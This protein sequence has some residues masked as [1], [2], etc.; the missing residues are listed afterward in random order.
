MI[1]ISWH[2]LGRYRTNSVRLYYTRPAELSKCFQGSIQFRGTAEDRS[3]VIVEG[4]VIKNRTPK[5][6][7]EV[8]LTGSIGHLRD[9]DAVEISD[10]VMAL[11]L[12]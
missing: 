1:R 11:I 7:P 12:D 4:F 10:L 8:D 9:S 6:R 2:L 3:V 5:T